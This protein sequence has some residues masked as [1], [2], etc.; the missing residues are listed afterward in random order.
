MSVTVREQRRGYKSVC[1]AMASAAL[2]ALS[3]ATAQTDTRFPQDPFSPSNASQNT[4]NRQQGTTRSENTP[5]QTNRSFESEQ[6]TNERSD[7]SRNNSLDQDRA[8]SG[9]RNDR[10]DSDSQQLQR[11]GAAKP[12]Q[13]PSEFETYVSELTGR[14]VRRFG[15][16]LLVPRARDFTA[17]PTATIPPDYRLNPGDEIVIG[18]SGSVEANNV[19]LVVDPQGRVFVPRVGAV[20]VAG[21]RFADLPAVLSRRISRQFRNFDLSVGIGRIKGITV[22]VTGFATTPGS[23]SV[24]SLSTIVNA[25]LAAGGPSTGGSF[26]SIQLRRGGRL[27]SDFDLYDLLLRGNKTG[28]AVLQNGDVIYLAPVGAQ[29]AV[30]GSVNSEAIF[31]VAPGESVTDV[32][33]NAGGLNTVADDGRA[34]ILNPFSKDAAPAWEQLTA[35]EAAGRPISRGVVVR[36]LSGI[37]LANPQLTQPV[38]VTIS[39]EV[40][41]PGRYYL[42]PGSRLS[43]LL[44]KVGG[45]TGQAFPFGTVIGRESVKELQRESYER[46]LRDLELT[47]TLKPV[48]AGNIAGNAANDA[49]FLTVAQSIVKQLRDRR[50]DGRLVLDLP[51]GSSNLPGDLMLENNDSILIPPRATSVGVFG[52]VNSPSSFYYNN[53]GRIKDYLGRAG[54]VQKF[55]DRKHL[56]VV[57]ANG[58]VLSGQRALSQPALPGDLIFVPIN[59]TRG[60]FWARLRDLSGVLLPAVTTAAVVAAASRR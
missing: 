8:D 23:Y 41:K 53:T 15:S 21:V 28:D 50:P 19:R 40:G 12:P 20:N 44:E 17:P 14:P 46:A 39:G 1:A 7:Q 42:P 60:E 16:N 55:G 34:L 3:P 29:V 51:L 10:N 38:L 47:L 18:L 48:V 4:A 6:L 59:A 9:N 58:T 57:R 37:G 33:T 49:S 13:L 56:F 2:F 32:L 31:E 25:V 36:I 43:D 45:L 26:R 27:V 54:G 52:A 24:N 5:V 11:T 30:I 22:F 35:A